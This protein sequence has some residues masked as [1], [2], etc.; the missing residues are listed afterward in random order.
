MLRKIKYHN[1]TISSIHGHQ[2]H[3][4]GQAV[5]SSHLRVPDGFENEPGKLSNK[6]HTPGYIT[7]KTVNEYSEE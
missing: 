3:S 7:V 6:L 4:A 2:S 5:T 1:T